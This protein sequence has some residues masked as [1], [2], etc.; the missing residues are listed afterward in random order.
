M[1]KKMMDVFEAIRTRRSIRKYQKEPIPNDKLEMIF[2]AARLAPSAANR[3][4]WRFIVVQ[5]AGRKKA[6]AKAANDRR[7]RYEG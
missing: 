5:D 6:L 1:R 4:P 3:Q 2:E 7:A